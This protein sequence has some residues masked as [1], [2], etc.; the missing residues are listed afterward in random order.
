M[1]ILILPGNDW[2]FGPKQY[3]H[4][5]AEIMGKRHK[6]YVWHFNL[7]QNKK[8]CF[9]KTENVHLIRPWFIRSNSLLLYYIANFIPHSILFAHLI[10]KLSIDAVIVANLIPALWAFFLSPKRVLK[11]FAFQD[12]F[13]ESVLVYYSGLPK[14]FRK[15]LEFIAYLVNK[16]SLKM[17]NIALCPCFSLIKLAKKMGCK[18]SFFIPNGVSTKLF[19]P[20]KYNPKLGKKLGLSNNTLV[21]YGLIESW[22]DFETVFSGLR[23]LK[24]EIPDVKILIIGSTL[25]NYTRKFKK[26]LQDAKLA[27]DVVL[28]GYVTEE[29]VAYYLNLGNICLMPYKMDKF[30][31]K[32]RLPLKFFIYSAMG[33]PILSVPLPEVKRFNPQHVFFYSDAKSFAYKALKILKNEKLRREI[34]V[35]AREFANNF[36]YSKIAKE[37]ETI[38]EKNLLKLR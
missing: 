19:D 38:L 3:L 36:D 33:K 10:R 13:P 15:I 14:T 31:G 8:P 21:F 26:L 18:R 20:K 22:L 27:D 28:T 25:T 35:Y 4:D 12:Y 37:C 2:I 34:N 1:R 5:I 23:I 9:Q 32:I 17:A 7:F 29:M 16:V 30:S 24:R 6:V 11:V